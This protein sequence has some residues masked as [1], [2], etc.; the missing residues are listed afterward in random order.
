MCLLVCLALDL[1][2]YFSCT[3]Y[4][5]PVNFDGQ[6]F[7]FRRCTSQNQNHNDNNQRHST[8]FHWIAF[9]LQMNKEIKNEWRNKDHFQ[10]RC[11][12]H[13]ALKEQYLI[14]FS[15]FFFKKKKKQ[16]W[17]R[18]VCQCEWWMEGPCC[19]NGPFST[20]IEVWAKADPM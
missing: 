16:K 12:H 15:L 20:S 17:I 14:F 2:Q 3:N 7:L 13:F 10:S 18:M 5:F 1:F 11:L 8:S 6:F 9:A 4:V 19:D